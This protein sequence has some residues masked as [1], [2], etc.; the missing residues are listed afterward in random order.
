MSF[1][2]WFAVGGGAAAGAW[3]RWGLNL[4]LSPLFPMVPL[5]TLVSNLLAGFLMGV[6]ME[7]IARYAALPPEI[8]LLMTTGFL[9]GLSTF[10]AFSAEITTLLT[11]KEYLWSVALISAHVVGSVAF[12]VLGIY[13]TRRFL[14]LGV[15]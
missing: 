4:W 5:G 9:G 8:K 10:S 7:L 3:L 15:A 6:A 12:T 1:A 11:H 14:V 13:I 2:N